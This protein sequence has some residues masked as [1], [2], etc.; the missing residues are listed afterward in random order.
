MFKTTL[1][2]KK[3]NKKIIVTS[4]WTTKVIWLNIVKLKT[5]MCFSLFELLVYE[6]SCHNFHIGY[7]KFLMSV[8]RCVEYN[9]LSLSLVL[10]INS[11]QVRKTIKVFL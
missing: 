1:Q 8:K 6:C 9:L 2:Y 11:N 4:S 10:L 7:D 3:I 5:S